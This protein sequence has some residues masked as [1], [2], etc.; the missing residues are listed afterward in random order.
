MTLRCG[1]TGPRVCP[2][3]ECGDPA[4]SIH[5][6]HSTMT[7]R[8]DGSS[9]RNGHSRWRDQDQHLRVEQVRHLPAMS[10]LERYLV[11]EV[12]PVLMVSPI[13]IGN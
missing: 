10:E 4:G 13:V 7:Q 5:F 2:N 11:V 6:S 1:R 8:C 12:S 9:P 3:P